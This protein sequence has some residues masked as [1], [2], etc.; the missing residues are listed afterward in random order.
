V[1]GIGKQALQV[2]ETDRYLRGAKTG[3]LI[4]FVGYGKNQSRNTDDAAASRY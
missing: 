1:P 3:D 4:I 2:G